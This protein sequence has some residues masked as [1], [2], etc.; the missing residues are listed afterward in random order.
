[1]LFTMPWP[2]PSRYNVLPGLKGKKRQT[3]IQ[4]ERSEQASRGGGPQNISRHAAPGLMLYVFGVG[5]MGRQQYGK[6]L[7]VDGW[8]G[9]AP[10]GW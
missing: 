3:R 9:G 2:S 4:E 1:M 6:N 7:D 5:G 10:G 8:V